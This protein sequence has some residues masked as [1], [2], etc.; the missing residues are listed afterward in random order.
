MPALYNDEIYL[1]SLAKHY[2]DIPAEHA[3]NYAVIGCVEPNVNDN[4]FGNTDCANVN[5]AM[6]F[7]QSLKGEESDLWNVGLADQMEKMTTKFFEYNCRR[8]NKFSKYILAKYLNARNRFKK[9]RTPAPKPPANMDELLTR[10]Q[11]RLNIITNSILSDHQ[12][13]EKVIAEHF[14]T[15]LSSTL[16]PN[17]IDSGKDLCQGGAKVNSSGIQAVGITDVADSLFAIDEVVF[18]NK[19][20]SITDVINAID[21]NF[22]GERN[23]EIRKAL[24]AVPKFGQDGSRKAA[25]SSNRT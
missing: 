12:A 1:P 24:F 20:Y 8:N 3:R 18:K 17:C 11:S 13:I 4:H 25:C 10:F 16:F 19:L 21:N 22:E 23:Q 2:P 5:V 14:T 9:K 6:P 7:L 15:P